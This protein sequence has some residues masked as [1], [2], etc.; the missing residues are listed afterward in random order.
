MDFTSGYPCFLQE[1]GYQLWMTAE[2]SP[3]T[4]TDFAA[5]Q[6]I[7]VERL[8]RSFSRSRLER[9]TE[10]DKTYLQAMA[11]HGPGPSYRS[12]DVATAMGKKT[13]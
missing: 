13:S 8:D 5:A 11:S 7:I 2:R 10:P 12:G 3:I 1:W 9:L 6:K 4:L